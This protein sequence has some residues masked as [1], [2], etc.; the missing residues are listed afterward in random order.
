MKLTDLSLR[1]QGRAGPGWSGPRDAAGRAR[2][3]SER[4]DSGGV[5]RPALRVA[6]LTEGTYPYVDGGVSTWCHILCQQLR[7]VEFSIYAVTG[8]TI[9]GEIYTPTPNRARVVQLP[10]W[11]TEDITEYVQPGVSGP[12]FFARKAATR[13]PHNLRPFLDAFGRLLD[14]ILRPDTVRPADVAIVLALHR[15]FQRFDYTTAFRRPETWASFRERVLAHL[16]ADPQL[17]QRPEPS[18]LDLAMGLR[19]LHNILA[20]IAAPVPDVEIMHATLAS[21]VA[22]MGVIAKRERGTPFVLTEHGVYMRERYISV[23]PGP[24]PW[25][26]KRLLIGLSSLASRLCFFAADIVAPV[27]AFNGRWETRLGVEPERL[28]VIYNGV[29]P[30]VFQPGPKPAEIAGRPTVVAAARITA[31]KDIL[32]MIEAAA[33]A[34]RAVPQLLVRVYGS[35]NADPAYTARCR[36]R[37]AELGL[38]QT[39]T[40]AG[41]HSRPAEIY[42]EGDISVL[43][44]ISEGFPYTVLEAMACERPVVATDVGGVREALEGFGIVVPPKDPEAL[45]RGMVALLTDPVRRLALGR[46]SREQVMARFRTELAAQQYLDLYHEVLRGPRRTAAS[47]PIAA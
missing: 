13:R 25:F 47:E 12:G 3:G 10:Q 17:S 21:V 44:S 26:L 14:L 11:C 18:V 23:S 45:G 24:M 36:A 6:M 28:R 5:R 43:S 37:I 22:L 7:E 8:D 9:A 19:W 31:I 16:R 4:N 46:R 33:V 2:S 41:F 29:D 35:L 32:T 42:N 34:K 39:F 20:P 27:C 15:W 38:E 30:E 1:P 40:L